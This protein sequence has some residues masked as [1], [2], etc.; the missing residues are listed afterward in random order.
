[1]MQDTLCVG[2]TLRNDGTFQK[3]AQS[4]RMA[5]WMKDH[6]GRWV[7]QARADRIGSSAAKRNDPG[8]EFFR[9]LLGRL[10]PRITVG[11]KAIDLAKEILDFASERL[12]LGVTPGR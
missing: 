2:S 11:R 1:M 7:S 12:V 8:I 3:N 9:P 5:C 6:R 10:D 4:S